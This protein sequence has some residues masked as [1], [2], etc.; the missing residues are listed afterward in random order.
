MAALTI[1]TGLG[2]DGPAEGAASFAQL[3]LARREALRPAEQRVVEHLLELDPTAPG[4]TAGAIANLLGVSQATV[5]NT[6]QRLGYAG[7]GEFRRR[8]IAERAVE[9]ATQRAAAP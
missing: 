1:D 2:L 9:Q 5:V 4:A 7:F 3:A 6:V 8:L